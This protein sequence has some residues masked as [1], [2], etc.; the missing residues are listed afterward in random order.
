M[1]GNPTSI[2]TQPEAEGPPAAAAAGVPVSQSAVPTART[3]TVVPP[4]MQNPSGFVPQTAQAQPV[5]PQYPQY[6][7][8]DPWSGARLPPGYV[9]PQAFDPWQNYVPRQPVI[10]AQPSLQAPWPQPA[11]A[12]QW[13]AFIPVPEPPPQRT[14]GVGAP[15]PPVV[16]GG[17]SSTGMNVLR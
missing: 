2:N 17:G 12:D 10:G 13:R 1:S 16:C 3:D 9:P 5:Q 6:P 7:D 8:V 4:P 11:L 14:G 15:T